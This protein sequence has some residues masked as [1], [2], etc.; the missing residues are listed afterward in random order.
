MKNDISDGYLNVRNGPGTMF[1]VMFTLS[2]G[3]T[4]IYRGYCRPAEPGGGKFDWCE[5]IVGNQSG[6][7]FGQR[8]RHEMIRRLALLVAAL[9]LPASAD[10]LPAGYVDLG[11][12]APTLLRTSAMPAAS[13]SPA[14]RCRDMRRALHPDHTATAQALIRVEA[15]LRRDGLG[16]ILWDCYR[17]TRA[18]DFFAHWPK[19]PRRLR[20]PRGWTLRMTPRPTLPCRMPSSCRDWR[21]TP[22]FAT[23]SSHEPPVI[24]AGIRWMSAFGA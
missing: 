5:I 21:A 2:A 17:P 6:W 12:L 19:P 10:P 18:V 8:H 20:L 7:V 1:D 3:G 23:G 14:A 13:T 24:P 16:L 22:C 15:R 4:G 11:T 9:A